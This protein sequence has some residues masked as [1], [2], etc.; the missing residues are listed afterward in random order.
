MFKENKLKK[1]IAIMGIILS[2][3][4]AV[5]AMEVDVPSTTISYYSLKEYVGGDA[6]NY[7]IEASLRAG[8][9]SGAMA[10][11]AIYYAC[12]GVLFVFSTFALASELDKMNL[13]KLSKKKKS[14]EDN[15]EA[16]VKDDIEILS[17][18]SIDIIQTNDADLSVQDN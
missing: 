4:F 2:I 17:N 3:V 16:K 10:Q 12:A 13:S 11:E 6:Y 8:E 1:I 9:I 5:L 18:D 15:D 14:K 7:Q